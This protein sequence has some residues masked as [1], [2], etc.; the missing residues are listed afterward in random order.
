MADL[1]KFK[2]SVAWYDANR[3]SLLTQYRGKY[4]AVCGDQVCGNWDDQLSG[5]RAMVKAGY[6]PG[7]FIVHQ[8]VPLEEETAYMCHTSNPHRNP[9]PL[10]A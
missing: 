5:L 1:T 7:T 2:E 6:T 10:F 3:D 8:C 9:V 4:V